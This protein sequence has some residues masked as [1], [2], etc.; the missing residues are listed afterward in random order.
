MYGFLKYDA[1]TKHQSSQNK[2]L[3]DSLK[4]VRR[5]N[6]SYYESLIQ[7]DVIVIKRL[8]ESA[9]ENALDKASLSSRKAI[10]EA[11]QFQLSSDARMMQLVL[12]YFSILKDEMHATR[13]RLEFDQVEGQ[14]QKQQAKRLRDVKIFARHLGMET[15][16][17]VFL[18]LLDPNSSQA[19]RCSTAIRE[20]MNRTLLQSAGYEDVKVLNVFKLEHT[21]LSRKLQVFAKDI[22]P[23]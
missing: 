8:I 18:N 14:R 2:K 3:F 7:H 5:L 10:D 19:K 12:E 6:K 15:Q 9:C 23:A 22:S 4:S 13:S 11:V 16:G 17:K 1:N 21:V 20:N